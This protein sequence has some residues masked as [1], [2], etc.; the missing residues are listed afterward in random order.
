[1]RST[2]LTIAAIAERLAGHV[3][4][5]TVGNWGDTP[6]TA[7]SGVGKEEAREMVQRILALKSAE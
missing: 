3:I 2:L 5:G 7:H 1:M 4:E 6:M